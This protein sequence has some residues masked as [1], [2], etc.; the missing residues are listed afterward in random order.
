MRQLA[1]TMAG[2][3]K[4]ESID[5]RNLQG[6][7]YFELINDLLEQLRPIGTDRDRAGN[8]QLFFDQYATLMILYFFN[9][10][11]LVSKSNGYYKQLEGVFFV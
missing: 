3:K 9:S 7:K 4:S 1:I 10:K 5:P 11:F 2:K 8:R 6:F